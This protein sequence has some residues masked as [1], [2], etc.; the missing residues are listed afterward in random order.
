MEGF[1]YQDNVNIEDHTFTVHTG[2]DPDK[3]LAI[4][5]VFDEG[6]FIYASHHHCNVRK[7]RSSGIDDKYIKRV[8]KELHDQVIDDIRIFFYIHEKLK[9]LRQANPH[10]RLGKIFFVHNFQQE[11]IENF[12]RA[13]QLNPKILKAYKLLALIYLKQKNYERARELLEQAHAIEP[14][15][16]DI[17][18]CLGVTY[19][20]AGKYEKA[21]NVLQ[22][23]L[24]IKEDFPEANFNLGILLFLSTLQD[25]KDEQNVVL[26]ARVLRT[27]KQ[28]REHESY[29]DAEWQ[30]LFAYTSDI[31]TSGE[32][33]KVI[34]ALEALQ[35]KL[36][37]SEQMNITMD[38]FFLKFMYGGKELRQDEL[39]K[40]E[41]IF[42]NEKDQFG[43]HADYWNELGVIHLIQC[44]D[45]FLK[46]LKEF[47][48]ATKINPK[49]QAALNSL[50]LMKHGK[51]GF[52]ILL[53]AILK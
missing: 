47:E 31:M 41:E 27:F 46:A 53:R 21:R 18:N 48:R 29:V 39:D 16:P 1:G 4:S 45:Y 2:Y 49:Y 15:F 14:D 22:T 33:A 35:L 10:Y 37:S 40:F 51:K 5:E 26:P 42:Q 38:S 28:I 11:A 52:L 19:T 24:K 13:I 17:L 9:V 36:V 7:K 8:A 6:K 20:H 12:E 3:G 43:K 30:D 34:E 50:G 32:R 23:A 44:R 25:N